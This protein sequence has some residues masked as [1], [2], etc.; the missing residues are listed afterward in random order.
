MPNETGVADERLEG[1]ERCRAVGR[2]AEVI[3][4]DAGE[5]RD[6]ALEIAA[7][8]DERGEALAGNKPAVGGPFESDSADL[9]DAV[10]RRVEAG[11]LEVDR[12]EL[13]QEARFLARRRRGDLKV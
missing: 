2:A 4:A 9:D 11:G 8:I 7:W 5:A 10:A 1:G 12:D 13:L 3:V 6:R